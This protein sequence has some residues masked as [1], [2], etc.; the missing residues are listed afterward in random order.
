MAK[1]RVGY[2][3]G[4]FRLVFVAILCLMVNCFLVLPTDS[5][6]ATA[7][8]STL[9]LGFDTEV[10]TASLVPSSTGTFIKSDDAEITVSTD[11][12]TGYTLSLAAS[13]NST[14]LVN[15]NN[16]EITSVSAPVSESDFTNS[17]AYNNQ[18][19]LKPSQFISTSGGV[20]TVV[21]NANYLPA[22]DTT[23]TLIDVTSL[24]NSVDNTYTLSFGV[25][26]DQQ[27]PTG[28]Y[29]YT[30]VVRA[31]A[32][33]ILYNVTFDKNTSE[34]V[35]NMPSPNPQVLEIAGGTPLADSYAP[36][37]SAIPT[38]TS[39]DQSFGGWCSVATTHNPVTDN[40]E[41]SGITYQAG[42][43]Y[44]IDQTVD[45][46]NITLYAIWI[47]DP[48]PMV[49]SQMGKC[50][51][52]GNEDDA[53]PGYISGAECQEHTSE[54][55]IDT[56]IALYSNENYE[57]DYEVHFTIDR[58]VYNNQP[59]V[60]STIFNDKLSSSVKG[61]PYGGKS[62]G[63]V[64]RKASTNNSFEI[65]SSYTTTPLDGTRTVVKT[66]FEGTDVRILRIDGVIYTSL[67]NGPLIELQDMTDPAFT[68]QFGLSA[69]FGAYPDNV[70]C[71]VNCTAA[72][73][74]LEGELSNMYIRLGDFDPSNLHTIT[75]DAN[76]GTLV[77]GNTLLVLD[78][79]AIGNSLEDPTRTNWLFDGWLDGD[80]HTVTAATVPTSDDTYTAQWTK[81][82]ELAVIANDPL[83]IEVG[84]SEAINVTNSSELEP[85]TFSSSNSSVASVNSSTGVVSGLAAGTVTIT[86]TGTRSGATK[87]ITVSIIGDD[88]EVTFDE[89]GGYRV[90]SIT[91]AQGA[92]LSEIPYTEKS[93]YVLD[94]WY[95]GTG[96]TGTKLTTSTSIL[97]DVTY[98]AYWLPGDFVCKA[99]TSLHTEQCTRSS[100]GCRA[101]GFSASQVITYGHLL[102][103]ASALTHG[104]AYD[105]DVDYDGIFDDDTE[106]FYYFGTENGNAK[107]VHYANQDNNSSVAYD[108]AVALLPNYELD[109]QNPLI[110]VWDNPNLVTYTTGTFAGKAARF[111]TYDEITGGLWDNTT[112]GLGPGGTSL[113]LVEMSNFAS[114][115]KTDGIWLQLSA[116]GGKN[117]IQTMS[118]SLTHDGNT[119]A[120]A[121]RATIEVPDA[122]LEKYFVKPADYTITF[123]PQNGTSTFTETINPG[124][125]LGSA[126]PSPDPTYLNHFFQ[127]W[128]DASTGGNL[129]TSA[130]KPS[131]NTTYYAQWKGNVSLATVA[132][133][134]ISVPANGT[135]TVSVTNAADLE[136]FTFSSSDTN[137]ATIDQDTGV[138]TPVA[139]G[140]TYIS[141]TGTTSSITTQIATVT[142]TSAVVQYEIVFNPHNETSTTTVYVNDGDTLGA[143][144]PATDPTYTNHLFQGWYT[145][146]TG[147]TQISSSTRP[148]GDT[149]YH[150]Q[151]LGTVAL[152]TF[153][154]NSISVEEE[155]T[156]IIIVTN[157]SVI[158]NYGFSSLNDS[159]ATVD[160]TTGVVTGVSA[161]TTSIRMTGAT[162]LTFVD[163][164]VT[165][166]APTMVCELAASGTLHTHDSSEYGQIA[167]NSTPQAG[168]AYNC[169]V[170]FDGTYNSANERFYYLD[171]DESHNAVLVAWNNYVTNA[172]GT[173]ASSE[174]LTYA[175]ALVALPGNGTGEWDNP[176]L[177]AQGANS[178]KAARFMTRTEVASACGV[179]V[180]VSDSLLNCDY[181]MEN[182][183]YDGGGRSAFWLMLEGSS[184]YRIHTGSGNRKVS[185]S[186]STATSAPR[187]AIVVPFKL[188]EKYSAP[189][190]TAVTF[191]A[192]NGESATTINVPNGSAIGSLMPNEPTYN[193]HVFQRWYDTATDNT[194]TS[195]TVPSSSMTVYAE[196]KLDVTQAIFANNDPTFAVGSQI[197]I[198]VSNSTALEPYT[199]SSSDITH[200]TVDENTGVVTGVG[201][202]T[203]DIIITGTQSNLTKSITVDVTSA[204]VS[205]YTVTFEYND[206]TP[207]TT[208]IVND[209][210][211]IGNRLPTPTRTNHKFFG[212]Y[213]DD[214]TFYEEVTPA[215]VVDDD[216]TYYARWIDDT[217]SFPIVWSETNACTFDGTHN[218][219]GDYCSA[220]NKVLPYINTAVQLFTQ[221]NYENDFEVGFTIVEYDP[222][223]N[224]SQATLVNSKQENSSNNYP[225]FVFRRA[226]TT[227]NFELTQ[228]WKGNA[229]ATQSFTSADVKSVRIVRRKE[230]VNGTDH[231]I[232]YYAINGG[233]LTPLQDITD[234]TKVY[235][236]TSVW[237]GMAVTSNG[238]GTQRPLVGTLTDMYVKLGLDTDYSIEF[239]PNNGSFSDPSDASRTVQIGH[240]LGALPVPIPPSS[241]YTFDAW[242]DESET[243]AVAISASTIPTSDKTYVAHYDYNSSTTPVLF[244]VSNAATRGYNTI[245]TSYLPQITTFNEDTTTVDPNYPL[246]PSIDYSSW[247]VDKNTYLSAL[248]NNF[249]S[250]DCM[251]AP[252]EDS[253]IDWGG[254]HTVNC[255]KP[256]IYDTSM[257]EALNVYLYDTTSET[258]GTQVTYTNSSDGKISNMIPG[259]SYYWEVASETSKY[260]VV[261]ATSVNDRRWLDAGGIWNIRDLGG[262]SA[263]YT[264]ENS[265]TV[266]GTVKFGKLFRGGRLWSTGSNITA[267]IN[268]GI[269]KQYD[270]ADANELADVK[271]GS[272]I[273]NTNPT[274]YYPGIYVNDPVKH[275]NFDY[276]TA[277]YAQTRKALKIGRAHV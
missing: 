23:G 105:C 235:F 70:D 239:D 226:T 19:G 107:L 211:T 129:I 103:S 14:S 91:I 262:L 203:A 31:V 199:F 263:S 219:S 223:A 86:M 104:A 243:P 102:D 270:L 73:R 196:W 245:V 269:D 161:G 123:D 152:A 204:V 237:F 179:D 53:V 17:S 256:D 275:Y 41:C 194:V 108:P 68:Q 16:D 128:F 153:A 230:V 80:G 197:T 113:Y 201:V 135:A 13:S 56:G 52:D 146:D 154:D 21:Q 134:T 15:S 180:T 205:Q 215:T 124:D 190:T 151:W 119:T 8:Q 252:A 156:G 247:G 218:V 193:D 200:A 189:S 101:K 214:G 268:L 260:G 164:P 216:I 266:N 32:N 75:L 44:P 25:R 67:D 171:Q 42:D 265:L 39:D 54:R 175:N 229:G 222:A 198:N 163:I 127:G 96:G 148:S 109:Q 100:S 274:E 177:I 60:Q 246:I 232:I 224:G 131:G 71:T 254:R 45:G 117:R 159:I 170:D 233:A 28:T 10:L 90:E 172:W 142:V 121:S 185:D 184:Y 88:C 87:D 209:G 51:F 94:G 58:Y 182:T 255:S 225:G 11:N 207:Q 114:T 195:L 43:D 22:P 2:E 267:L 150:A 221:S 130:T 4:R 74:F 139:E 249:E 277:G 84:D 48:F 35:T 62:P 165:V 97:D 259:Q 27:L 6:S 69:W 174:N 40:D 187:P 261:T 30:Y 3:F 106:R 202:G 77:G 72:K 160:P 29:S 208:E 181:M 120:N 271:F 173:G 220:S 18:W 158:E 36:L 228:K 167:N 143:N 257:G 248:Q 149:T 240:Q 1:L 92:V 85:Y 133:D 227:D 206:S 111:M 212:W 186:N 24:A 95:T 110:P 59:D 7:K 78:G 238:T 46:T 112:A 157:A 213:T 38:M 236:D 99:A 137:I 125:T 33:D 132:S 122:Y 241:D 49:W 136:G 47:S 272:A 144:Y 12:F 34:T 63:I 83:A 168:D 188:I 66:D 76:G 20:N 98:H 242:Y 276:G 234:V 191:D 183:G 9:S 82:V 65:K 115:T 253:Q 251:L 57:K 126:Y 258:V 217:S 50:I 166:T 55:F 192:Q 116:N 176:K 231:I 273:P 210:D 250:N 89:D 118:C 140:T 147:G 79:N 93:G 169:D 155:D 37:S 81:T 64:V 138:I 162:S 178:D 264:D 5:A 141:I 244:E 145:A 61:S 26:A